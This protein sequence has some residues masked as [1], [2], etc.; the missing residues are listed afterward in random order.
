MPMPSEPAPHLD[1]DPA[2]ELR[3][4]Y[5]QDLVGSLRCF[6]RVIMHGTLIDVA[7]PG[8]LLVSM[9][10]AGFKPRDLA[11]YAQP[12]TAKVPVCCIATATLPLAERIT[13]LIRNEYGSNPL[14]C[15]CPLKV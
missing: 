3:A 12:F 7:H 11:R 9:Q 15:M 6:D 10:A 8:A 4:R 14:S 2:T 13:A 1:T 5:A